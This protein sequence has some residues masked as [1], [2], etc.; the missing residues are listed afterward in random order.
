[1]RVR[2]AFDSMDARILPDMGL[3]AAFRENAKADDKAPA[4]ASRSSVRV[5][6]EA[7]RRSGERDIVWVVQNNRLERRAVTLGAREGG[8]IVVLA[9]LVGG[10]RVVVKGPAEMTEGQRISEKS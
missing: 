1:V 8:E 7:V 2:V 4:A 10:E 6:F 3:K 5:P 9:G